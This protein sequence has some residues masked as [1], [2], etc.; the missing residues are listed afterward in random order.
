MVRKNTSEQ[1]NDFSLMRGSIFSYVD[2]RVKENLKKCFSCYNDG[3]EYQNR[4]KTMIEIELSDKILSYMSW[5]L[6]R[7][8]GTSKELF[9]P[10]LEIIL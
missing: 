5:T 8:N 9:F 1:N 3:N 4:K 7:V 10:G 6:C 2:F